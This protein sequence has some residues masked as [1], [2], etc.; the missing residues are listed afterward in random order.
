MSD[1]PAGHQRKKSAELRGQA[2]A[3]GACALFD[4]PA[5]VLD[6]KL[7]TKGDDGNWYPFNVEAMLAAVIARQTETMI[8][9][10]VVT[11]IDEAARPD[12]LGLID[13]KA[14]AGLEQ[15]FEWVT[16]TADPSVVDNQNPGYATPLF[17]RWTKA[18]WEIVSVT[19][20]PTTISTCMCKAVGVLRRAVTVSGGA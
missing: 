11:E 10:D 16:V 19:V 12:V 9:P 2:L 14:E 20:L 7:Q 4:I 8:V 13:I 6:G 18:G 17:E 1:V 3:W 15:S 5:A